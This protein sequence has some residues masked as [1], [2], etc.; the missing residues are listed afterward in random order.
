MSGFDNEFNPE[1]VNRLMQARRTV[2][3]PQFDERV[4]DRPIIEQILENANW[5]PT[6]GLR[7]PWRFK[8]YSGTARR[9]L[10]D[11]LPQLYLNS[12]PEEKRKPGKAEKLAANPLKASHVIALIMSP[13][14]SG[15]IP[16]IEDVEAVACAV[17]NM[18]LSARAYGI[19]SFWS[20]GAIIYESAARDIVGLAGEDQLLGFLYLGYPKHF[21]P[22]GAREPISDRVEWVDG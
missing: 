17:Q 14:I 6:H 19:G 3:P 12:T 13:D 16:E 2:K 5:A 18:Q 1:D 15:K 21:F 7:Q 4:I 20:T 11:L 8:V 9:H 22:P 10:S